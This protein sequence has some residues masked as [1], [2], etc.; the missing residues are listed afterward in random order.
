MANFHV[1]IVGAGLAGPLLANGLLASGVSVAVYEKLGTEIKRDGYQMRIAQPSFKSFE[2]L[3]DAEKYDKIRGKMGHF[4]ENQRTT[5]HWYDSKFNFIFDFGRLNNE[6]HGSAPMDRV[7]LRNVLMEEPLKHNVVHFAKGFNRYEIL[8][9]NQ[10]NEKV[11]V[12]FDDGSSSDCDLLI[13][14]DGSRSKVGQCYKSGSN[15][16][17]LHEHFSAGQPNNW[18]QQYS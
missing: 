14:A 18:A 8:N 11:R 13:G 10:A 16:E 3:L 15:I 1:I 4:S 2:M 9:F 6:Y 7:V 17:H 5:P 12:W